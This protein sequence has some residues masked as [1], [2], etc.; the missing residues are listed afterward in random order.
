MKKKLM[1]V[2]VL[3]GALSLGACVDDNESAS[4]TNIRNAKAEQLTALAEK[5]RAEGEAAKIMAEAE[6]AL[7]E[8]QA[9]YR[10]EQTEEARQKFEI[11][12]EKIRAQ[13]EAEIAKAKLQ[14]QRYEQKLLDEASAYVKN[15]YDT[16]KTA[17]DDL[18][19][20][21]KSKT[22]ANYK[23]AQL[24]AGSENLQAFIN[25]ETADLN[26]QIAEKEAAKEAWSTYE[27]NDKSELEAQK[28]VLLQEQTNAQATC[29]E[30]SANVTAKEQAALN[31]LLPFDATEAEKSSIKAVA[32]VQEFWS[33]VGRSI[34]V[35]D[36]LNDRY[37]IVYPVKTKTFE[38]SEDLNIGDVVANAAKE[39]YIS[40]YDK[41]LLNQY[42]SDRTAITDILGQKGSNTQIG[43][44][45]Y[46]DLA[47]AQKDNT[48]KQ[49]AYEKAATELAELEKTVAGAK[50]AIAA[51]EK[52]LK[53][54]QTE[55]TEASKAVDAA[56][57]VV[58][59]L[60]AD[61][62]DVE[63]AEAELALAQAKA[64]LTVADAAVTAA[65]AN[66]DKLNADNADALTKYNELKYTTVPNA[67]EAAKE[68]ELLVAN[69]QESIA[70]WEEE[71]VN[72]DKNAGL[73]NA[74]VT[75]L[76]SDEYAKAIEG[77]KSNTDVA[78][79]IAANATLNEANKA[80]NKIGQEL[81]VI[82]QLIS[83]AYDVEEEIANID[84][85]IAS[86]KYQ[87]EQLA[88]TEFDLDN[89][90]NVENSQANLN[91]LIAQQE[92]YIVYLEEQIAYQEQ[93]VEIFKASLEEAINNDNGSEEQ[94]AA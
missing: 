15:A 50:D 9:A 10:Q 38:L 77:M 93:I 71:L 59:D 49:A 60:P 22:N 87:L 83:G 48:E 21:Q 35:W 63:R 41:T 39:Y 7:K 23:L 45:L 65:Q 11:E 73:W 90:G 37:T 86:L 80:Y 28:A 68:A 91:K 20:L 46:N 70:Y 64:A 16:Y 94:P 84:K 51:A 30:A 62:S 88:Y 24:Q 54:A 5:A 26:N 40:D 43:S 69:L 25:A 44:G 3:L 75:A 8:A 2:A 52:E 89:D 29:D 55:Q 61:A 85:D 66:L 79:Y 76:E 27:G 78:A 36:E 17:A 47:N 74:L 14:A 31:A 13:A 53:D 1:M 82:S 56:Q 42:Y 12:I 72:F 4:V 32:A 58:N 6:A 92:A 34:N 33:E 57:K 19:D 81:I 67:E 18:Y